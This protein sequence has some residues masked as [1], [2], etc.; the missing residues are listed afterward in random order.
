MDQLFKIEGFLTDFNGLEK[1]LKFFKSSDNK[2]GDRYFFNLEMVKKDEKNDGLYYLTISSNCRDAPGK[3]D[4]FKK[5]TEY[6][7]EIYWTSYD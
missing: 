6:L 3:P 2:G 7:N 4:A 1:I 5:L